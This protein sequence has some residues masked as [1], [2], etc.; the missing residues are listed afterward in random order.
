MDYREDHGASWVPL[1]GIV[2]G[3]QGAPAPK[4][5]RGTGWGQSSK[6]EPLTADC[7]SH[8]MPLGGLN[9]AFERS[10]LT[11]IP[12][13][14]YTYRV[15][16]YN[17][18]R[19]PVPEVQEENTTQTGTTDDAILNDKFDGPAIEVYAGPMTREVY[20]QSFL[21]VDQMLQDSMEE[22]TTAAAV[23]VVPPRPCKRRGRKSSKFDV[24]LN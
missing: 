11:G 24:F 6:V 10:S 21:L 19:V 13:L 20:I 9:P 5:T 12:G 23:L 22:L 3:G 1:V 2:W 4:A 7:N 17:N 16:N 18:Q 15:S 8:A 14:D